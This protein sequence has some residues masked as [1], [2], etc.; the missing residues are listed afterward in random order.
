[1]SVDG[2][3]VKAESSPGGLRKSPISGS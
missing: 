3:I 1:V 2:G